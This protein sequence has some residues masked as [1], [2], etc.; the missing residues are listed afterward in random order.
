VNPS[1]GTVAASDIV[2]NDGFDYFLVAQNVTQ[3][4]ST[5]TRYNVIYDS[6]GLS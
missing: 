1:S 5:P 2:S 3:G 4:T 6:T